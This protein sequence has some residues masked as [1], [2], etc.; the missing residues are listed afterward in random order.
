MENIFVCGKIVAH[1]PH[2]K[3]LQSNILNPDKHTNIHT[4]NTHT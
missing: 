1:F 4:H 2:K 3:F